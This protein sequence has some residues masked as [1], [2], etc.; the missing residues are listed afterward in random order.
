[1]TAGIIAQV[2]EEALYAGHV[3]ANERKLTYEDLLQMVY[4]AYA[5]FMQKKFEDQQATPEQMSLGEMLQDFEL[6][7]TEDK[8]KRKIAKL[9]VQ[10]VHLPGNAG[11]FSVTPLDSE[12]RP[13]QC[14]TL[15][16]TP[17][18]SEWLYCKDAADPFAYFAQ[19][20]DYIV[21][22]NLDECVKKVMAN[23]VG[24]DED[25]NIPDDIGWDVFKA[26]YAQILRTYAIPIDK[27][28]D[29]NPNPDEIFL[30]KLTAPQPNR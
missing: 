26:V 11:V 21:F 14:K 9:P 24:S 15:I 7:I 25:A 6:D 29:G 3:K 8:Y 28:A 30:T 20:R 22:Y 5:W 19:Y 13:V 4:M 17:A 16:R 12:G 18:G 23:L 10:V 2:L 27:R 1:M